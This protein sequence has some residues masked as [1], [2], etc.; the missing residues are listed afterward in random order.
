M[1]NRV[2]PAPYYEIVIG[3]WLNSKTIIRKKGEAQITCRKDEFP[4]SVIQRLDH[5]EPYWCLLD[6]RSPT[7]RVL[8]IGHGCHYSQDS[9]MIQFL[10]TENDTIPPLSFIG[11]S[12]W[13][14]PI[15][16]RSWKFFNF[17][18]NFSKKIMNNKN[19]YKRK[20]KEFY[21]KEK[22]SDM[23][24][25]FDGDE[26][27]VYLHKIIIDSNNEDLI[28]KYFVTENHVDYYLPE[29]NENERVIW[30]SILQ[31]CYSIEINSSSILKNDL[32]SNVLS[33]RGG[34]GKAGWK[35]KVKKYY[36]R[37]EYSDIDIQVSEAE[38]IPGHKILLSLHSDY[39]YTMF[40]SCML[41]SLSPILVL[42]SLPSSPSSSSVSSSSYSSVSSKKQEGIEE[43]FNVNTVMLYYIYHFEIETYPNLLYHLF[44]S[45]NSSIN[46][47]N[48]MLESDRI[49][50]SPINDYLISV[51]SNAKKLKNGNEE[52]NEK[53]NE[54][55]DLI[56]EKN[57]IELMGIS[58]LIIRI[59]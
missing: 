10:D 45:T 5:Y 19:N 36:G 58:E 54:K 7:S 14:S 57:V 41:E 32:V 12:S 2:N 59:R 44:H 34:N 9:M 18:P 6:T 48:L 4:H 37:K 26:D 31:S 27:F 33:S 55:N 40:H 52:E 16:F 47:Y 38:V 49:G 20:L 29:K 51:I 50:L 28:E 21:N 30:E 13:S 17:L 3:G 39:Y 43:E 24:L 25:H 1:E 35:E 56:N 23:K 11:V 22:F 53:Q 46:L 15:D 42:S 8:S